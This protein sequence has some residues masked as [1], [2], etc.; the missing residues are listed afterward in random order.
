[1]EKPRKNFQRLFNAYLKLNSNIKLYVA[2]QEGWGKI[3]IKNTNKIRLLGKVS[4]QELKWLYQNCL[5]F[6]YPSIWEG[7]GYPLLEAMS[8]GKPI[9]SSYSSSLKEI[10][11]EV[12]LFFDPFNEK[13]IQIKMEEIINDKKLREN[14]SRHSQERARQFRWKKT[15]KIIIN[16]LLEK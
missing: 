13:E 16:H 1:L 15:I 14:L 5:A 8:Y 10:G 7:F 2:G 3:K 12:A 6:V 11:Q 4:D 9:I